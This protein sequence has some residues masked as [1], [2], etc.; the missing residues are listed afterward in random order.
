MPKMKT[1]TTSKKRFKKLASGL[2]KRS[3]AFHRKMLTKK[4]A[5]RKRMLREGAYVNPSNIRAI[6]QLLPNG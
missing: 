4:T 6:S 2:I 3:R 1:R 5:K